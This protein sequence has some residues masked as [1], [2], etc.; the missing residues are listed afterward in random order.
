MLLQLCVRRETGL[1]PDQCWIL[2]TTISFLI[3]SQKKKK[4]FVS[5]ETK[6]VDLVEVR[7]LLQSPL[8]LS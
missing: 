3:S 1:H 4:R 8:V 7:V 2:K 5:S 6:V